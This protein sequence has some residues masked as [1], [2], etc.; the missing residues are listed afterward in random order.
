MSLF[1]I[2]CDWW[3]SRE[4]ASLTN[5]KKPRPKIEPKSYDGE[6]NAV[7]SADKKIIVEMDDVDDVK[8]IIILLTYNNKHSINLSNWWIETNGKLRNTRV[9][10]NKGI[11]EV[12]IV[13]EE[14]KTSLRLE[15]EKHFSDK[16]F[17]WLKL[18]KVKE[19]WT[20]NEIEL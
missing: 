20:R 12:F 19:N 10:Y 18:I 13:P 11:I 2:G 4:I 9:D 8:G 14:K 3:A 5:I 6:I 7:S 16:D 17:D 1:L 15:A